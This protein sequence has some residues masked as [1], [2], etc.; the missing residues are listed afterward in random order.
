MIKD[1]YLVNKEK[2]KR[3]FEEIQDVIWRNKLTSFEACLI[4]NECYTTLVM[5]RYHQSKDKLDD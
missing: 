5:D 3:I 4:I 1:E 2:F